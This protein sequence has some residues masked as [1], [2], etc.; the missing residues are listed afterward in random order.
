VPALKDSLGQ[1]FYVSR[2]AYWENI[3]QAANFDLDVANEVINQF[4]GQDTISKHVAVT[5]CISLFNRFSEECL[6]PDEI[7]KRASDDR[8]KQL[9]DL[10]AHYKNSLTNGQPQQADFSIIQQNALE[11]LQQSPNSDKLFKHIIIDEYQDT[12]TIQERI[13]FKLS[14]GSQNLCV[15]GDDDQ[16]LYRFRGATVE[17]FVDF[18][19][20]CRSY[21]GC[22]AEAIPLN[23]NYRS[24][25]SIVNFYTDFISRQNWRKING[26]G[27]YRIEDKDIQAFNQDKKA[28]VIASTAAKPELVCAEIADLVKRLI[29][30]GKVQDPN[31]VAFLYPSLK[32]TQVQRMKGALEEVGLQVY[33]PRA[34]R[35]LEVDEAVAVFG[36]YL[37]IFDKPVRGEY[38]GADY[39]DFHKWMDNCQKKGRDLIKHDRDLARFVEEKRTELTT[40]VK[41]Y[42]ILSQVILQNN[43]T[44]NQPYNPAMMKRDLYSAKGISDTAKKTL[45]STYFERVIKR[46]IEDGKPFSLGYVLNSSTSL[47]WS[48]LDL[49]YRLCIF[50]HFKTMFDLA[51]TGRDEGPICNM[52][53]ITQYLARFIDEYA[54]VITA[55]FVN[56]NKFQLTFFMSF[57]YSLFRLGET[58]Y[59]DANDPFPRG[60]IPFLTIHQSKGLEFPVVV[61]GNP[62]K[63]AKL[64]RMEEI[65][66]P[67]LD[68]EGEPLERMANFDVMRMFYVALSR[69]KNLLIIAHFKG[70]GQKVSPP[71]N[72][73][74]ANKNLTRIPD[75]DIESLPRAEQDTDDLPRN[76][77]YTS[78]YLLYQRCPRQYMM[79]RKYGFVASRSQTMFFGSVVHKTIE[80]LHYLLMDQRARRQS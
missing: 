57:L 36:I 39:N 46:R 30:T 5:N 64:Q 9:I 1:Y 28:S 80:D 51:E 24:R 16:A 71:F 72:D 23:I 18:P 21:F 3:L 11:V 27:F 59:E 68:R 19:E 53:L 79:F 33:A 54:N 74:L 49:F 32:S 41:D 50:T 14:S 70:K 7:K 37:L 43:W 77:S 73:M 55:Q 29:E 58:E 62:R 15:V 17:N 38:S 69:A 42:E 75:F 67:L 45:G 63:D 2:R 4:F 61:L 12:N 66:R 25:Y 20:R 31:Q 40:I 8:L 65:V 48:V 60:R 34:G 47:D 52:G 26:T 6:N 13:F 76:Y 78:D 44:L 35:F 22:E 56:E 10:Y